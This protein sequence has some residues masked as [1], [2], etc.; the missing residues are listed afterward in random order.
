MRMS[1]D[2]ARAKFFSKVV[3][4]INSMNPS[5]GTLDLSSVSRPS[6]NALTAHGSNERQDLWPCSKVEHPN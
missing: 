2:H 5:K 6:S 1:R 3:N 4:S